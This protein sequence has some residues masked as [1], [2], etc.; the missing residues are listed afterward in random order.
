MGTDGPTIDAEAER[1]GGGWRGRG[2]GKRGGDKE[3]GDVMRDA[4]E[5]VRKKIEGKRV[6]KK[7]KTGRKNRG[8]CWLTVQ[9]KQ[10]R[11]KAKRWTEI[12]G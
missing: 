2:D 9:Q 10:Q 4:P 5:V 1:Q 8:V 11:N 6:S 7:K 12:Q 3:A